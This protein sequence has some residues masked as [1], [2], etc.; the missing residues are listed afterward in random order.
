MTEIKQTS[1]DKQYR[2]YEV[3][4]DGEV[5]ITDPVYMRDG[6]LKAEFREKVIYRFEAAG[7]WDVMVVP[8]MTVPDHRNGA[9]IAVKHGTDPDTGLWLRQEH[10]VYVDA[11]LVA[12]YPMELGLITDSN[13]FF[14]ELDEATAPDHGMAI[15]AEVQGM[16][17]CSSGLGDG[18]YGL[19]V[20]KDADGAIGAARHDPTRPGRQSRAPARPA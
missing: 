7:T 9:L 6:N 8:L 2:S 13:G 1:N 15:L 19:Y 18:A 3:T 14:D 4:V 5:A 11:G 12:F 17:V 20:R 10:E 16:L